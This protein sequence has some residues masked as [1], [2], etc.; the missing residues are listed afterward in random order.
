MG[1]GQGH[2]PRLSSVL[3]MAGKWI[4][5]QSPPLESCSDC[6]LTKPTAPAA[7]WPL[8]DHCKGRGVG[9]PAEGS[10]GL[11]PLQTRSGAS[12]S[13]SLSFL[14]C[15]MEEM[16]PLTALLQRLSKTMHSEELRQCLAPAGSPSSPQPC[17]TPEI[18]DFPLLNF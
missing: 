4:S 14:I 5:L 2:C 9:S 3:E 15:K 7:H 18:E 8:C 11:F 16:I 12:H 10:A 6:S 1:P 13:R 17:P